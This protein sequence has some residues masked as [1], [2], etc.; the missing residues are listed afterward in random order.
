MIVGIG[1][2]RIAIA[3]VE[4]TLARFGARFLARVFTE[5]EVREAHARADAARR[6]AMCFAAKE[7]AAKALGTGFRQGVAPCMIETHHEPTGRPVLR[8]HGAAR[9]HAQRLGVREVLVSLT[10]DGGVAMAFAVALR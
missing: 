4:R 7:A 10:D 9:A 3:R 1:I 5:G 8:L 6:L 2:D